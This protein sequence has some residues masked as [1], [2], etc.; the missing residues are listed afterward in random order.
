MDRPLTRVAEIAHVR[1]EIAAL[2]AKQ[3]LAGIHCIK[4][5]RVGN[6]SVKTGTDTEGSLTLGTEPS[7]TGQVR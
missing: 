2:D 5:N 3:G 1:A 7:W 4:I 6:G